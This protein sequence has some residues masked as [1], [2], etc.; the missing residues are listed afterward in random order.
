MDHLVAGTPL[1]RFYSRGSPYPKK[2][3]ATSLTSTT[4]SATH[5]ASKIDF[6]HLRKLP[7]ARTRATRT[8]NRLPHANTRSG[9]TRLVK[10]LLPYP[11][12]LTLAP[13][14]LRPHCAAKDRLE[15]WPPHPDSLPFLGPPETLE[16]QE[17]VRAVTLEGW[18]ESTRAT[19]GAGLLVYHIFC[20][21]RGVPETDRALAKAA[22]VLSFISAL[23][24]S[25]SGKAIH[26]YIC[27]VRAWH[28]LYS[29]PWVLHEDQIATML[30]GVAKL[31]P[32]A[33][34]QDKR[35][36]VTIQMMSLIKDRLDQS[37]PFDAAFF[38]C[39]T[40]TFYTAAR[41]GEFTLQRLDA[42]N[43]VEHITRGGIHD[44]TD[45][46]GLHTKVFALL[47]TKSSHAGEE[48]QWAR[49]DGSTDPLD[50]FNKHIEINNP[51]INGPLFAY[52]TVKGFRPMTW[53]TF[54]VRLNKFAQA[55]GLERIHGHG[56]RIGATLEYLLHGYREYNPMAQEHEGIECLV[57][58]SLRQVPWFG[59]KE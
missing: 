35:K 16:L 54:I 27:R 47:R 18:A 33:V 53:Q 13:S 44:D 15:K 24:G 17:R 7:T 38:T 57:G 43:P 31:A 29:L 48:V 10:T 28:M 59:N 11:I 20:D 36:P 5:S 30:K 56:I 49:Q 22:L 51:P 41:V 25:L 39:L 50:A 6:T 52:K 3:T 12:N 4:P 26:N 2:L 23:A 45:R 19:Y 8:P 46:N 58:D 42:F 14:V 37:N 34:K 40:T 32:P 21:S 55:A 1:L 9:N